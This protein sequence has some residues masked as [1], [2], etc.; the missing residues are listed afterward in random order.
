MTY[1][2]V[3]LYTYLR[4]YT[5]VY[6][7]IYIHTTLFRETQTTERTRRT[8]RQSAHDARTSLLRKA[9]A[10]IGESVR[11][12]VPGRTLTCT[13]TRAPGDVHT[14]ITLTHLPRPSLWVLETA[15]KNTRAV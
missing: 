2:H 11:R 12:L 5:Y 3:T 4:I 13:Q 15:P 8:K 7:R 14:H 9:N 1:I 6:I 10:C